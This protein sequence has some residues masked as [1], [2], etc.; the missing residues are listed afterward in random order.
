[1]ADKEVPQCIHFKLSSFLSTDRVA[2]LH[3]YELEAIMDLKATAV[4]RIDK[5]QTNE[6]EN[7]ITPCPTCIPFI[8][9]KMMILHLMS[10][11]SPVSSDIRCS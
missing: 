7:E 11:S 3:L 9:K 2:L 5:H 6:T 4:E 1:M 8:K 10:Y